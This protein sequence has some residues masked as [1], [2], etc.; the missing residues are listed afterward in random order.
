[1]ATQHIDDL[2]VS[3]NTIRCGSV[4]REIPLTETASN[5]PRTL[6]REGDA[7]RMPFPQASDET[8]PD[9]AMTSAKSRDLSRCIQ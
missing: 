3:S 7:E 2:H 8:A 4:A 9:G 5:E 6:Q 1:M